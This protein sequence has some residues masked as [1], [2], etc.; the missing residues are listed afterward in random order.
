[1]AD[2]KTALSAKISIG[3]TTGTIQNNLDDDGVALPSG[4]YCFTLDGSNAQKEHIV[5]DLAGTALSNIQSV[6]R[7]GVLTT[8]VVREHRVNAPV[9][10]TDY[11]HIRLINN[12]LKGTDALDSANPLK[13]DANPTYTDDKQL[14]ARKYADDLAIA[15][16][17]DASTSVKGISKLSVAPVSSTDPIA[18]GDNDTRVPT[19]GENDALVG[20]SGTP[21][22]SNKYVTNDDTAENTA[23]K[24]VRRKSDSNITVPT[25]P[26]ATTDAASKSYVDAG[27]PSYKNGSSS[28]NSNGT[29]T[30]AHGLGSTPKFVKIFAG[31][32]SGTSVHGPLWSTGSYN[33]AT[34]STMSIGC[35]GSSGYVPFINNDTTNIVNIADQVATVTAT[36]TVDAT[37][38]TLTWVGNINSWNILFTW[39]AYK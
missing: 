20:T 31:I 28:I 16:S 15:G 25:T 4:K 14:I 29:Q 37:N 3:G 9:S 27:T 8:G 35:S 13:Y 34:T 33:G 32:S 10:I 17:P 39:E 21:S 6:S 22:S 2:F 19:Q 18:V 12:I 7:Q 30:I 1:M 36:V 26:S 11:S 23:S 24:L 38:I 5:C